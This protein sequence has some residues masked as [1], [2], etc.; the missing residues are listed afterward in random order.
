M[1]NR[2]HENT[3]PNPTFVIHQETVQARLNY[4]EYEKTKIDSMLEKI[5]DEIKY[6]EGEEESLSALIKYFD[7]QEERKSKS[8]LFLFK[9]SYWYPIDIDKDYIESA[10]KRLGNVKSRIKSCKNKKL[11]R[12]SLLKFLTED[13]RLL[14]SMFKAQ[15]RSKYYE[16]IAIDAV[17]GGF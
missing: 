10:K 1:N 16:M 17:G 12:E 9:D 3:Q 8:G 7:L 14:Q 5:I 15:F 2:F 4:A 6:L 13:I 11:E